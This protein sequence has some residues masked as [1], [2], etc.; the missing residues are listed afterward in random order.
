MGSI[1]SN[2]GQEF[3][4][5]NAE[6]VIVG[7]LNESAQWVKTEVAPSAETQDRPLEI[8]ESATKKVENVKVEGVE[9]PSA[10]LLVDESASKI[11]G[12]PM[13][14]GAVARLALRAAAENCYRQSNFEKPRNTDFR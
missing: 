2:V 12:F 6:G 13:V 8:V 10:A 14:D 4:Y 1:L 11:R 7:E 3:V 9:I 5:V